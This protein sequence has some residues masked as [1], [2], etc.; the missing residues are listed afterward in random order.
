M[1]LPL[2]F[3]TWSPAEGINSGLTPEM[4]DCQPR[5]AMAYF[6]AELAMRQMLRRCNTAVSH[7]SDG[8]IEFAPVVARELGS[9]LEHWRVFLPDSLRFELGYDP[10]GGFSSAH[11]LYL[12]AQYW[13]CMASI[14]WP[15]AVNVL[16]T[17]STSS[18]T[19]Q[20]C[21]EFFAA[22]EHFVS[23]AVA[24]IELC[25]PNWWTLHVRCVCHMFTAI[26]T[27]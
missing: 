20:K 4:Q 21:R 26:M 5:E 10:A 1:A 13:S 23:A 3:D 16:E 17:H 8:S 9:Q 2:D 11:A 14:A 15:S 12:K 7:C 27:E 25:C 19:I 24:A 6:L 18:T 22:Y